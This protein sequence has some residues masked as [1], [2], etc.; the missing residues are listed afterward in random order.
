MKIHTEPIY[1]LSVSR[2][3]RMQSV[4]D[5][6]PPYQRE[7]GVWNEKTRQTLI[8]SIINGLDIPKLY[9]ERETVRRLNPEGLTYQYA[10]IDGKQRLEAIIEFL[11]D[12][13]TLASD[14]QFY[15]DDTVNARGLTLTDLQLEHPLLA[16]RFLDFDLPVI[17][18]TTDSGDLIEEMFQ[19]L[20]AS[21]SLNAAE[22]RNAV[23]GA[24]RE[25]VNELAENELLT[26][27]SPIKNARYK[28][29]EL[30]AKFLAI[31]NQLAT[32]SRIVDTKAATLYDLFWAT[33][34]S[35]PRIS[36]TDMRAYYDF[37]VDT[38][39][40]MNDVFDVSDRLLAS[41]G[42]VVVYYIVFRS[43]ALR[44]NIDRGKLE[45]FEQARR[46]V[47]GMGEDSPE[48]SR[49]ANVRLREYNVY[50]QSTN[51]GRA[52]ERRAQILATYLEAPS[53]VAG[54][55]ALDELGDGEPPERDEDEE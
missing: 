2:F 14:F 8:D 32:R 18:V 29:R 12:S 46:T 17:S 38:L 7:G 44:P 24:T 13:L 26:S 31:E 19:R 48:Y 52:L 21:T 10:V 11:T 45:Q 55:A 47:A 49:A 25:A 50:V 51:D 43:A 40:A 28:Y 15:E 23:S 53:A 54:L 1:E 42:T 3:S 9:F 39:N 33:H 41:I 16:R 27:R 37:A 20:N 36:D 34:V 6:A 35:P 30:A 4:V 22:R 5:F